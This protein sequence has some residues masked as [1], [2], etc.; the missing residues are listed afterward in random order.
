VGLT[1]FRVVVSVVLFCLPFILF[2]IL[3]GKPDNMLLLLFPFFGAVPAILSSLLIFSPLETMLDNSKKPHLKNLF[4][5]LAGAAIIFVF[6]LI[7]GTLS[8]NLGM[9]LGRMN[10]GDANVWGVY[11]V[12]SV[13]GMVWGVIWRLTDHLAKWVGLSND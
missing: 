5:P 1:L 3:S 4:I 6:M 7:V 8:G 2:I 11:A 10:S 9:L 12:W 13:A